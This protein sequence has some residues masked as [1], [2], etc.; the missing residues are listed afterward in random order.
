[1]THTSGARRMITF[2]DGDVRFNY[3]VVGIALHAQRVLL[4]R[5]E[6]ED[7][8]SLPGGRGELLEPSP[9][10][11]KREI[12]EEL[13]VEVHVERLAWVVENFFKYNAQA[14]HELALYFKVVFPP[15]CAQLA[16]DVFYGHEPGVRL[17]F[18]WFP[19]DT[20]DEVRLYPSFLRSG[21][22]AIPLSV[23]HIVHRD[24]SSD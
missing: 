15:D 12:R 2:A 6:H 17:I 1:M 23:T 21:L 14:F 10:T 7:F 24:A 22:R 19:V 16:K 4:H 11:I 3:R 9:D 5:S 18:Q 13:D 8:W 20:L